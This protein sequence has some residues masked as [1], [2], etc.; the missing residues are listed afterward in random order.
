MPRFGDSRRSSRSATLKVLR[1]S[2]QVRSAAEALKMPYRTVKR[3]LVSNKVC[4]LL[5]L[6]GGA[7]IQ[8]SELELEVRVAH[9]TY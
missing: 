5:S 1:L 2:F 7:E 6:S 8:D 3:Q 4:A 9:A